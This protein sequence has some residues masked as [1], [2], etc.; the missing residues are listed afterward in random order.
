MYSFLKNHVLTCQVCQEAKR[1]IHPDKIPIQPTPMARPFA[2]W[3]MDCHGPFPESLEPESDSQKPKCYVIAFIDQST[4]WPELCA[5]ADITAPTIVHAIFDNIIARFGLSNSMVLQSDSASNFT[6]QLTK[7]FCETF[8]VK[9]NFSA[10]YHPQP[11]SK[12]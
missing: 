6:T 9:Q 4:L 1:P 11:N 10:P 12:V 7:A 3:I 2:R 5:V 8:G